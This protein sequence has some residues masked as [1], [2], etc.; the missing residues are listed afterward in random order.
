MSATVLLVASAILALFY[1][2]FMTHAA[3]SALRSATKTGSI[4]LLALAAAPFPILALAL[5]LSAFGD[6]ALSR[7]CER[8]LLVGVAAFALAHL[9]YVAVF[10]SLGGDPALP[11]D[12]RIGGAIGIMGLS[13]VMARLLWS[14]AGRLRWTVLGYVVIIALMGVSALQVPSPY[15]EFVIAA[16]LLFILSDSLIATERFLIGDG[17]APRWLSP[18]IWLTYWLAQFLF[19]VGIAQLF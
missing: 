15:A 19:C 10:Q 16:A 14:K 18:A 13:S 12:W 8:P 5:G 6:L 17:P 1:L 2:L 7:A 9:T 4:A 3:P 11:F